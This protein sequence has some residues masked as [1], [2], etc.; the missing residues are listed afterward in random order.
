MVD[1][2][3]W[4]YVLILSVLLEIISAVRK[5]KDSELFMSSHILRCVKGTF[6]PK[7]FYEESA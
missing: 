6:P 7:G 2:Y 3:L 4:F 1:V 5:I